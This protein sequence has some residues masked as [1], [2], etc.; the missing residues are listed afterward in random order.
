M[1]I[2]PFTIL[3]LIGSKCFCQEET[4]FKYQTQNV[5]APYW[6]SRSD[7]KN[8][9]TVISFFDQYN[10]LRYKEELKSRIVKPDKRNIQYLDKMLQLLTDEQLLESQINTIDFPDSL[11]ETKD[12]MEMSSSPAVLPNPLTKYLSVLPKITVKDNGNV[13]V[14]IYNPT[15]S[16]I[17]ITLRDEDG[18]SLHKDQTALEHYGKLLNLNEL[19]EGGYNLS[20]SSG[21]LAVKY[22]VSVATNHYEVNVRQIASF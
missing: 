11:Y 21:G 14:Y 22:H 17:E 20:L 7:P 2:L 3:L 6:V 5:A 9:N 13:F 16:P 19:E 18:N 15:Q 4:Y 1:K 12:M 10:Q 8:G